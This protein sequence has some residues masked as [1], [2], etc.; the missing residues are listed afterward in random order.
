MGHPIWQMAMLSKPLFLLPVAQEGMAKGPKA[1]GGA[2]SV[3]PLNVFTERKIAPII[4]KGEVF[5]VLGASPGMTGAR[6]GSRLEQGDFQL[7]S[8]GSPFLLS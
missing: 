5:L 8:P 1:G 7:L 4:S 2:N 3:G 6:S